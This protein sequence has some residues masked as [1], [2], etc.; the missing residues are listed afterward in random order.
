MTTK[1]Y[2]DYAAYVRQLMARRMAHLLHIAAHMHVFVYRHTGGAIGGRIS[3]SQVLLLTTTGRLTGQKRTTPVTYLTHDKAIVIVAGAAG[4]A[5]HPAWWLNLKANPE[6]RVQIGPCTLRVSATEA[7]P[8]ERQR[9]WFRYP[10]Q[11]AL[12][13]SMLRRAQRTFPVAIL[14]P[15]EYRHCEEVRPSWRFSV[16]QMSAL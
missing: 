8:E 5:K 11:Y 10:G 4:A 1:D 3:G 16:R 15:T 2:K 6:A 7:T 9:I 13:N 14:H 12:V